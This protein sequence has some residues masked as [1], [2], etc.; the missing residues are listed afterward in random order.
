MKM[1][2]LKCPAC[3]ASIEVEKGRESC[4]CSYCGTKVYVD[5]E[6]HRVEITKNINYH[7]T[8]TDEAK[9]RKVESEERMHEQ[10]FAERRAERKDKKWA[11]LLPV[12]LVIIGIL[13]YKISFNNYFDN[14][15]AESDR[16]EQELQE[17]VDE[18]MIDIENGD[19]EQ[20]YVK[21]EKIRYT[22]N[23]SSE[24]EDKWD[25]IRK[26]IVKQIEKAEKAA[27]KD[28]GGGTWWNP[29]D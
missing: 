22:E 15:K 27:N 25:A 18:I 29:F 17:L 10:E 26:E 5:D 1:Y 14:E 12:V 16:Q 6:V 20:A 3:G 21:A 11:K 28:E 19:F 24:I 13:A 9:I 4:F 23:W 8:Y 7:K 2:Q